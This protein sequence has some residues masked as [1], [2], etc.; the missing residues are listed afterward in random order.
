MPSLMNN[1][2]IRYF[3]ESKEELGKVTWPTRREAVNHT[4]LV[5]VISL[6]FAAF[7]GFIDFVLTYGLEKLLS[8]KR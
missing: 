1:P 8:L 5:I 2:V 4:F 3:K 7:F 6:A